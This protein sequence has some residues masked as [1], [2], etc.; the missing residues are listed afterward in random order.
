M[1]NECLFL[2]F[3]YYKYYFST[4]LLIIFYI[5]EHKFNQKKWFVIKVTQG[6]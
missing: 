3:V 4:T 2:K 1:A 6:A 5:T